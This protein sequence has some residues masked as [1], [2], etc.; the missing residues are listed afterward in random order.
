[1][2]RDSGTQRGQRHIQ[3]GRQSVRNIL[4][5]ATLTARTYNPL[6]KAMAERLTKAGKP[7]KVMMTACLRKLLTLL[8]TMVRNKEAWRPEC[9]EKPATTTA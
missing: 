2:N 7:F 6:I 5:M 9:P 8:N 3:G 1:M 4:Y